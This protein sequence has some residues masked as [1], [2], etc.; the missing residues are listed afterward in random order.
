MEVRI[1]AEAGCLGAEV[2][3][4]VGVRG[5]GGVE[6]GHSGAGIGAGVG[7]EVG[8]GGKRV[9]FGGGRLEVVLR[10]G[11]RVGV[12]LL[13]VGWRVGGGGGD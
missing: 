11:V 2:R 5:G 13:E 8:K 4:C 6:V 7:V 9:E 3:I 10:V 12:E 1:E